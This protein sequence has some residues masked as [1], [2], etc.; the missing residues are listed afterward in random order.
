[1]LP[2]VVKESP[3][4]GKSVSCTELIPVLI[5]AIKE[6]QKMIEELKVEVRQLKNKDLMAKTQ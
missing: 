5:E 6:Q 2:E 4:T 1:M 3:D